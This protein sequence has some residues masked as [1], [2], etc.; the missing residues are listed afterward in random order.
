M[1]TISR[2]PFAPLDGAR[3]QGLTSLKNRQ[4]AIAPPS[5][6]KRKAEL[7]DAD[8]FENVDPLVSAKRT[9]GASGTPTKDILK[10]PMSYVLTRAATTPSA[11]V[12]A[13][14]SPV[15]PSTAPRRALQPKSPIAKINTNVTKSSPISAPAGRS[16]TRGKRSG[17]LSNRR[18]TAGPYTRVD[19]PSFSLDSAAP[20]SLDAALKGTIP[21]YGSRPRSNALSQGSAPS[22][23]EPDM[24]A[25][26]FFDIHEDTPEQEMT[27]LLQHGT[28]VLDISSD[29]ESEQKARRENAEGRDKEN[30]PP[31][32][33]VSQTS[34][35]RARA[36]AADDMIVEKE[37]IALGEMNTADFYADG[38]DKSS[39]IIVPADD[40][41]QEQS[42][43][44]A[45]TGQDFAFAPELVKTSSPSKDIEELMAKSQL[46]SK[47]AVLRPIEGTGESF[48]LWESGSAQD[49]T[50]LS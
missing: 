14:A 22:L 31:V 23:G 13:L 48:D 20:F 35:R 37:R 34:A 27:N 5:N 47:A 4:N 50:E 19:P 2:Q 43:D 41:E 9:K 49:E 39:V 7:L 44:E 17:I 26:W 32:D 29:E 15:K 6:T 1:A 12:R 21:S 25:S 38:C 36:L 40:E 18:R 33:D 46:P 45:H 30:I 8:D 28:C 24:K 11:H 10:K 42:G 3:L 16:P